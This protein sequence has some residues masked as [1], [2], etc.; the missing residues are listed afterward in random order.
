[1]KQF[2]SL[3]GFPS[4]DMDAL[5]RGQESSDDDED[6]NFDQD[7]DEEDSSSSMGDDSIDALYS[8]SED[9][10]DPSSLSSSHLQLSE[11]RVPFW[12]AFEEPCHASR[13][14]RIYARELKLDKDRGTDSRRLPN[15][16]GSIER[17]PLCYLKN[18]QIENDDGQN[19]QN[20]QNFQ[21]EEEESP[22]MTLDFVKIYRRDIRQVGSTVSE[23]GRA[24]LLTK[25]DDDGMPREISKLSDA[26]CWERH[27]MI[28][29]PSSFIY[30]LPVWGSAEFCF[31]V[32]PHKKAIGYAKEP[33]NFTK[34][35]P[36][37]YLPNQSID[38]RN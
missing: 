11:S 26:S 7:E 34:Y 21:N 36:S 38:T 13:I 12:F 19:Y 4:Q 25:W 20:W 6:A 2:Q 27:R 28:D 29:V 22:F 32:T 3:N 23:M 14:V 31:E 9:E 24:T 33:F 30:C 5:F 8:S 1:M 16:V 10:E 15:F 35:L 37:H 17:Q 18:Y